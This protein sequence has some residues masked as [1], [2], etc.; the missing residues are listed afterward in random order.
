[1]STKPL[2]GL[3]YP[4]VTGESQSVAFRRVLS[5]FP[6]MQL[7]S[8]Y[9]DGKLPTWAEVWFAEAPDDCLFL[10]SIKNMTVAAIAGR[11]AT[12]PERLRGRVVIIIHHEPD[13]WRSTSDDRGDPHPDVWWQMQIEF[14]NLR[15]M[16]A[17]RDW[18][19]HMVV[20]T[21]DRARTDA[22]FWEAHWGN[23]VPNE[24][25]IDIIG[26]DC[27]NIGRTTIRLGEDIFN[28]PIKYGQRCGRHVII[29]EYGQVVPKDT[30]DDNALVAERILE[31]WAYAKSQIAG[32]LVPVIYAI[33]WYYNHNNTLVDP[34]GNR[35]GRPLTAQSVR[36]MLTD[37]R[38]IDEEPE[39]PDPEHPQYQWGYTV[40]VQDGQVQVVNAVEQSLVPF[41]NGTNS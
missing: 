29:R 19:F 27:F 6:D 11:V 13:Q 3:T 40:G 41:E 35:P 33:V 37:A 22:A 2:V 14:A 9:Y 20:F 36:T 24:P 23:R 1:M 38:T 30:A 18:I 39:Q 12:L 10:I 4:T 15:E 31:N 26:W 34:S 25:R 5:E 28:I 32:D 17:W 8:H 7:W 16:A 21:E